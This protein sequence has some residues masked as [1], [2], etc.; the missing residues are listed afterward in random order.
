MENKRAGNSGSEA[1][2]TPRV[3]QRRRFRD[4]V[5]LSIVGFGGLMLGATP[6]EQTNRLIAWALQYCQRLTTAI[7]MARKTEAIVSDFLSLNIPFIFPL[8]GTAVVLPDLV[9]LRMRLEVT[10]A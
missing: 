1:R 10:W 7:A 6:Q 8:L 9:H 4:E 2:P 3:L 5:E